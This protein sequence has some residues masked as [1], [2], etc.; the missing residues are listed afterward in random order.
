MG[1]P[2]DMAQAENACLQDRYINPPTPE[3]IEA[4]EK[5]EAEQRAWQE[6]QVAEGE[7]TI[8]RQLRAAALEGALRSPDAKNGG[9]VLQI[10]SEYLAF[11]KGGS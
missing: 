2:A 11:L 4:R 10:A 6:R 7:A 9:E 3:M 8:E 5:A 1:E